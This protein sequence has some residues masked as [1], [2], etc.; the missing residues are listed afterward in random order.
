MSEIVVPE[1]KTVSMEDYE[2]MK[3]D[4]IKYKGQVRSFEEDTKRKDEAAL[5]EKEEWKKLAELKEREAKESDEKSKRLAQAV[6]KRLKVDSVKDECLKIGLRKE[7]ISDLGLL[8]FE[9]LQVQQNTDGEYQVL[10]AKDE[11][12]RIK[13]LRPHWFGA[14]KPNVNGGLPEVESVSGKLV[15]IADINKAEEDAKKTGDWAAA[16]ALVKRFNNQ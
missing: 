16:T 5:R 4:M 13:M 14:N 10:G 2:R 12:E 3:S 9:V 6:V 15:T 11:A 7:A 8:S 1:T